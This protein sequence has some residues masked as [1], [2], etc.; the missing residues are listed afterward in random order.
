MSKAR[1]SKVGSAQPAWSRGDCAR[2]W[3]PCGEGS[4]GEGGLQGP[5]LTVSRMVKGLKCSS[6]AWRE[7]VSCWGAPER[8]PRKTWAG[9][10][11]AG[12]PANP[13]SHQGQQLWFSVVWRHPAA[14][15]WNCRRCAA[16]IRLGHCRRREPSDQ[17]APERAVAPGLHPACWAPRVLCEVLRL[18]PC[19]P[20]HGVLKGQAAWLDE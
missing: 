12:G 19:A 17:A 15:T 4:A 7:A 14:G 1:G 5:M 10:P 16:F 20:H 9:I 8:E 6:S 18:S 2:S 3:A 13:N 11:E